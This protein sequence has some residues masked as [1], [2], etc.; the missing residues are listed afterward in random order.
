MAI[1]TAGKGGGKGIRRGEGHWRALLG[2]FAR[3]GLSATAFCRGESVSTASLYRWR[4]LL[5][6]PGRDVAHAAPSTPNSSGF[7]DLGALRGPGPEA[8][9]GVLDLKLDLGN[10]VVLHLVRR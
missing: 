4:A 6:A 3:S 2:R 5:A 1:A 7:L 8:Q 9:A 10:G